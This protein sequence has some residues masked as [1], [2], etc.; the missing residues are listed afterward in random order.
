[1]FVYVPNEDVDGLAVVG[2]KHNVRG[3]Q[4]GLQNVN[5]TWRHLLQLVK[6]EDRASAFRQVPLHPTLQLLLQTNGGTVSSDQ[7]TK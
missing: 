7:G 3:T 5:E 1:M 4:K 6:N 2:A